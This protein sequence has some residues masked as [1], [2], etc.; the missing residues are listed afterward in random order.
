MGINFCTLDS[1]ELRALCIKENWFTCGTTKQYE[2][3]FETLKEKRP[4]H[5]LVTIIWICSSNASKNY[6]E[7]KILER[8]KEKRHKNRVYAVI[9]STSAEDVDVSVFASYNDAVAHFDE[10]KADDVGWQE[11]AFCDGVPKEGYCLDKNWEFDDN[12]EHELW[13]HLYGQSEEEVKVI[14][15]RFLPLE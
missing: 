1:A 14:E 11:E 8:E 3:L 12:E 4:I 7:A 9:L 5:E 13:W 10:I 2:M 6:I 15:L